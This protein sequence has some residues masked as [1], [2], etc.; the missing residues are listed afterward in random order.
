M[1][2]GQGAA[3]LH[4]RHWW[5]NQAVLHRFISDLL[6]DEF[7]RL[8]PGKSCL[9]PQALAD[10]VRIGEDLGADSLELV[11][12]ATALTEAIHLH[13]SGIE[14][15]LL[16]RR[17]VAD[18]AAT[19]AQ[20][21]DVFSSRLTFRTSGSTGMPKPCTH[22]LSALCEE[23]EYLA[24]LFPGRRRILSAVPC[25]HIYGFLFTVLLPDAL[26]IRCDA[27][28]DIRDTLPSV[29]ARR[30][31]PG[32]L[33]IGH[34]EFWRAL[35]R[36]VPSIVHD[37]VGITSSGPC[38]DAVSDAVTGAGLDALY[39][40]YGSSETAGIGWRKTRSEPY[41]L[42]PFWSIDNAKPDCL[43]RAHIDGRSEDAVIQ[44]LLEWKGPTAFQVGGRLDD[45]VQVGGINVFPRQVREV[46]LRHPDVEDASVRLMRPEEG[47]RLKAFVV[48]KPGVSHDGA[49]YS[50]LCDWAAAHL[51]PVARPRAITFGHRIPRAASGKLEDWSLHAIAD[52]H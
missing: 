16:V 17:T 22:E 34:P 35:A 26:G 39:Q 12:L 41:R 9:T 4:A 20:G 43:I 51:A 7:R 47:S 19:A 49:L 40:I 24:P 13:E 23:V 44:D 28:I 46:L 6:L 8:R 48:P 30:L 14:D 42:F 2:A 5:N 29:L 37:V 25:H 38:P 52:S 3:A 50:A 31:Q 27:V 36:S 1:S 15:Y 10:N 18:W 32:D 45:A 11:S 21:L 33:V